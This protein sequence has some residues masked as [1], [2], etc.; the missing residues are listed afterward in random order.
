MGLGWRLTL[1]V[2]CLWTNVVQGAADV[3]PDPFGS[4]QWPVMVSEHFGQATVVMDPR[5]RVTGPRFAE[6]A[7]NVPVT[8]DASAVG[9]VMEVVVL[10]DRNPIRKV[11]QFYPGWASPV[12]SFRFKLQQSSA[13]RAAAR[14]RD[15]VW[16]V[17][18]AWVEATGGGCTVPGASRSSGSWVDT[19]NQVQGRFY[20]RGAGARLRLRVM[21]PM[22]TGLVSGIPAF[23]IDELSLADR[24]GTE[25]LRLLTF[26]PVSENPIFSFDLAA[27]PPG[28]LTVRGRDNNGNRISAVIAR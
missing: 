24:S 14:T 18:G 1:T 20:P 4:G 10:V 6:D 22:D 2:V 7:M 19:L 8:V 23:Y 11:L 3:P 21:H 5:V 15:G 13:V 9:E 12:L 27:V 26:E 28:G 16:H 17:G 25:Y